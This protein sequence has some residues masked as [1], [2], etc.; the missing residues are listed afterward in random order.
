M[1]DP[2]A[3]LGEL[4]DKLNQQQVVER[5]L[6][7][8]ADVN[9]GYELFPGTVGS[10][11]MP[12]WRTSQ[13]LMFL[14]IALRSTEAR[15]DR[16]TFGWVVSAQN[17]ARFLRRLT[18]SPSNAFYVQ[19]LDDTLGGVRTSFW[20]NGLAISPNAL[21][22]LALTELRVSIDRLEREQAERGPGRAAEV[23]TDIP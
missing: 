3:A 17:A 12:D 11:P 23:P 4:V 13:P 6:L 16:N 5:P 9:G 1:A 8:P 19:S 10:P 21:T 14:A 18:F 20:D 2:L 7:G 22:L 15:G